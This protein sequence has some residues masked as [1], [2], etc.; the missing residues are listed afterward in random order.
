MKP[1]A[2]CPCFEQL[3]R[4]VEKCIRRLRATPCA[5]KTCAVAGSP[6]ASCSAGS[7]APFGISRQEVLRPK[8]RVSAADWSRADE[9]PLDRGRDRPALRLCRRQRLHPAFPQAHQADAVAVSAGCRRDRPARHARSRQVAVR[10]RLG[11]KKL[12]RCAR[13]LRRSS[14]AASPGERLSE[15]PTMSRGQQSAHQVRPHRG[16][17]QKPGSRS[18]AIQ[19]WPKAKEG[20]Q[21]TEA[22]GGGK[23]RAFALRAA[24]IRLTS[25]MP[26]NNM[27]DCLSKLAGPP[28]AISLIARII[29]AT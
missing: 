23:R 22:E 26:A 20:R 29:Q 21:G 1:S 16:Q 24:G 5:S 13:C 7:R 25:G 10:A 9:T 18:A 8:T 14:A 19:R 12:R 4:A 2:S 27:P 11:P 15:E 17:R 3:A 28:L 6:R